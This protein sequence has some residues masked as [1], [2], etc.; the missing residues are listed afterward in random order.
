MPVT[1]GILLLLLSLFGW[2]LAM[3]LADDTRAPHRWRDEFLAMFYLPLL[4]GVCA[5]GLGQLSTGLALPLLG[6]QPW[7]GADLSTAAGPAVALAVCGYWLIV[8]PRRA[9]RPTAVAPH[10]PCAPTPASMS[11]STAIPTAL[12][13]A[14]PTHGVSGDAGRRTA[15]APPRRAA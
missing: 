9:A 11:R 1:T 4:T 13:T 5:V 7:S 15:G 12:P 2:R 6:R 3:Y 10:Q 8:R 14:T